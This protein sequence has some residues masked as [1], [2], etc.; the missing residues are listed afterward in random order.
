M[1]GGHSVVDA[2][3]FDIAL[4]RD[5]HGFQMTDVARATYKSAAVN[6]DQHP[7]FVTGRNTRFGGKRF[8]VNASDGGNIKTR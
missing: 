1:F 6:I 5:G 4:R 8:C 7:F 2:D 3:H